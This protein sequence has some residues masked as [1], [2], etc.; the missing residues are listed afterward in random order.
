MQKLRV[1]TQSVCGGIT[2]LLVMILLSCMVFN[3]FHYSERL[4]RGRLFSASLFGMKLALH[5]FPYYDNSKAGV[6]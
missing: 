6:S 2:K 4:R 5:F 3:S 1:I